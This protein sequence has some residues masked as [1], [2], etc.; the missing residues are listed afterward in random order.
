MKKKD[1]VSIKNQI[2][3]LANEKRVNLDKIINELSVLFEKIVTEES[4]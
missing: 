3:I 2:D 1:I 4:E